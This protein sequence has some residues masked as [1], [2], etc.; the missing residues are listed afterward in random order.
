MNLRTIFVRDRLSV[1]GACVSPENNSGRENHATDRSTSFLRRLSL[2]GRRTTL[3]LLN[4]ET[5][6]AQLD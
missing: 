5:G 4:L 1:C 2:I 6:A 3:T